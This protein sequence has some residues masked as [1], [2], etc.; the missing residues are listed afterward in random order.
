MVR[1][2]PR[3]LNRRHFSLLCG[4]ALLGQAPQDS[5]E[6]EWHDAK[7]LTIEGLGFQDL[8]S[9]Y[10]RLPGRAEGV[11]RQAV[12]DLSRHSAGVLV[13]FSTNSPS[14]KAR[15]ARTKEE[16]AGVNMTAISASGLDLYTKTVPGKWRWLGFGRPEK[17]IQSESV[18]I[19]GV[20]KGERE[21]ML[22]LPLFNGV[23]S[24]EIGVPRGT[25][26]NPGVPRPANQKPILFYGT[27]I[28]HG[29]SA[30]RSGMTHVAILGRQFDR[31]VINLGFSG[32]GKMEPE[33]T[34]F[35]TELDPA[36]FVIDCL[37]NMVAKEVEERTEPCVRTIREKHPN[38]PILLVE[39]RNYPDG[40]L[41]PSRRERNQTSQKALQ[42]AYK[43]LQQ[44]GVKNLHYLKAE[45][46]LGDDGEG[47]TD[48]SHP[49]DL[50]FVRQ[51]EAFAKPLRQILK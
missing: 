41:I 49:S 46:L 2:Y 31:P 11:V 25:G 44:A 38:T 42:D 28:T 23:T 4:S 22:Y 9:P 40:F 33:V 45:T 48:G 27:S 47:T 39:D 51:A 50:G 18:L 29:A 3:M 1:L 19:N 16:L 36:V 6:Y 7:K 20:P 24:L 17:T 34:K 35:I 26:I 43:R 8:K 15:W 14:L 37:P 12:W 10:D 30:S 13:R 32:N 21:Y 5:T